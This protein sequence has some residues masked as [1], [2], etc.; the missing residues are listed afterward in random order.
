MTFTITCIGEPLG[1]ITNAGGLRVSFG[2]DVLNTDVYCARA[3]NQSTRVRLVSAL[4]PDVLSGEALDFMASEAIDTS[5]VRRH[6][7]RAMGLYAI[8]T[9]AQGERSFHYWRD[10]SAAKTLFEDTGACEFEAL[11]GNDI[12]YLSGITLAILSPK[13]RGNLLAALSKAKD[14]GAKIAF[15]SNYRPHLWDNMDEARDAISALW[16]ITDIALPTIEDEQ[17]LFEGTSDSAII[18]RLLA[19]G[20]TFGALK[21]GAVGPCPFPDHDVRKDF[22]P[23][24]T[25]VDTTGAGDSFNGAFLAAI[26]DGATATKAA[27]R[28]HEIAR[29]VV[30]V[31]GAIA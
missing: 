9:D 27:H 18:D 19:S 25:V 31:H 22:A 7:T 8:R 30:A 6:A 23:A 3:A 29:R 10:T 2:G 20:A 16:R 26:A 12:I 13:G 24:E 11:P 17:A 28:A 14:A 1:E 21:R 4:G 15:D 5:Y